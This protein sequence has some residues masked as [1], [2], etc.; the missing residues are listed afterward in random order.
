[1]SQGKLEMLQPR[2]RL[3]RFSNK[4][5][6]FLNYGFHKA[7]QFQR[8]ARDCELRNADWA[9]LRHP[10]SL[11][12]EATPLQALVSSSAKWGPKWPDSRG[13]EQLQTPLSKILHN[14]RMCR[15][16]NEQPICEHLRAEFSNLD[17]FSPSLGTVCCATQYFSQGCPGS[18]F[19]FFFWLF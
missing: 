4:S 2:Y 13:C 6:F 12:Q 14:K 1:M 7:A 15:R 8:P 19:T 5:F 11:G 18:S 17:R 10:F 9:C 16:E 3:T